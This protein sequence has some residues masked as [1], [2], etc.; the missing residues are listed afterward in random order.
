MR[1]INIADLSG[2]GLRRLGLDRSKL[3]ETG[4][5]SYADTARW[6]EA[7]HRFDD[8]VNGIIWVSRQF[9]T[10]KALLAFGD[11][12]KE[13]D[14]AMIGEPERLDQ[15]GGYRRAHPRWLVPG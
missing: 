2:H 15:G 13:A 12:L 5:W 6:A 9:D 10:A 11:R 8:S 4:A 7:I 3:L 1:D 14:L